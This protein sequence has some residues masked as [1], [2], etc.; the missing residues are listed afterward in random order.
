MAKLEEKNKYQVLK[1]MQ[2]N[3]ETHALLVR[4]QNGTASVEKFG[5]ILHFKDNLKREVI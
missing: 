4:M 1:R 3:K 2:S 5:V